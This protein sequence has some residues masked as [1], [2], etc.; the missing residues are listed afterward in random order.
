L[1]QAYEIADQQGS[2]FYASSYFLALSQLDEFALIVREY[3]NAPESEFTT[4]LER[5]L[6]GHTTLMSRTNVQE[7]LLQL[8]DFIT[9]F[10]ELPVEQI[11]FSIQDIFEE[12]PNASQNELAEFVLERYGNETV[13]FDTEKLSTSIDNNLLSTDPLFILLD[14]IIFTQEMSR[15]NQSIFIAYA[16]PVQKIYNDAIRQVFNN[17]LITSD[18]NGILRTNSGSII[19]IGDSYL[20]EGLFNF[21]SKAPGSA[22]INNKGELVGIIGDKTSKDLSSNYL[23][24]DS[25][26]S[27]SVIDL[28]NYLN[29][30]PLINN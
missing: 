30:L 24:V 22:V 16:Q 4:R 13:L 26:Q 12:L 18:A 1:R 5:L 28:S 14:E 7:E 23:F 10:N 3:L 19:R 20:I 25:P 17:E 29:R 21:T 8:A 6:N 9:I 11:P 2:S 15:N 27:Y